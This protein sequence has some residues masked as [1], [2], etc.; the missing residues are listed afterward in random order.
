MLTPTD[1]ELEI[2]TVVWELGPSTV[3]QVFD[4][5]ARRRRV[6]YTT[7]L[8]LMQ[9]MAEKGLVR[10]D[11]AQR[12]HVYRAAVAAERVQRHLVSDLA[13]RA[14]G[15]SATRLALRAL[16]DEPASAVEL[17]EIRRLLEARTE[18]P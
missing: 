18:K 17:E 5:L 8:K 14:F 11:E 9:I 2:L 4:A 7:V 6:G 1:G 13:R 12:S 16:A 10:R 15:G 3:R